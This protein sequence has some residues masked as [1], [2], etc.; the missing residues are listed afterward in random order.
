M[1][2]AKIGKERFVTSF[3]GPFERFG[4]GKGAVAEQGNARAVCGTDR[5]W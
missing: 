5:L 1:G 3:Q 4:R 2:R